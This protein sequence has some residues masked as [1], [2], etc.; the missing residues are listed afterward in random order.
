MNLLSMYFLHILIS[1]LS[2]DYVLYL[3]EEKPQ[4]ESEQSPDQSNET[5]AEAKSDEK[6]EEPEQQ[7]NQS[8]STNPES[9]SEEAKVVNDTEKEKSTEE[10]SKTVNEANVKSDKLSD[11]AKS[12]NTTASSNNTKV[13]TKLEVVKESLEAEIVKVDIAPLSTQAIV[14][15]KTK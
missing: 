9:K 14:E 6:V 8:D 5:T 7:L 2:F 10:T 12:A 13:T 1:V 4:A 3:D 11:D 15:S